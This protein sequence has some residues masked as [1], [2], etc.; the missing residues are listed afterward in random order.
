MLSGK[1]GTMFHS[2]YLKANRSPSAEGNELLQGRM[3]LF[4]RR[5]DIVQQFSGSKGFPLGRF[6][7]DIGESLPG[8]KGKTA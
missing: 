2:V 8:L 3:L 6:L 1:N 4:S 7:Q 5:G